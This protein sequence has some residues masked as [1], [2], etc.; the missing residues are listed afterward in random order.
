MELEITNED[1]LDKFNED[2]DEI[3]RIFSLDRSSNLGAGRTFEYWIAHRFLGF[4][5]ED[6][7]LVV[8]G[9]SGDKGIDIGSAGNI[10]DTI[11][12]VQCKFSNSIFEKQYPSYGDDVIEELIRGHKKLKNQNDSASASFNR[13]ITDFKFAENQN[14]TLRRI[15]C[16]TGKFNDEAIELARKNEIEI[17]DINPILRH[18]RNL[19]SFYTTPPTEINIPVEN[20]NFVLRKDSNSDTKAVILPIHAYTIYQ[21]VKENG[22]A[23]FAGNLRLR[24]P[25]TRQNSIGREIRDVALGLL[26]TENPYD[27]YNFEIL[28]NGLNIVCDSIQ[29]TG[30]FDPNSREEYINFHD[31]KILEAKL[32][33][34]QIVNGCQTS[35]AIHD[36]VDTRLRDKEIVNQNDLYLS[37]VYVWTKIIPTKKNADLIDKITTASNTQNPITK[38]DLKANHPIN[39][40][41][42]EILEN[43]DI[44]IFYENKRSL[45]ASF[46]KY[47][48]GKEELNKFKISGKSFRKISIEDFAQLS[49]AWQGNPRI[50]RSAKK[51]IFD[52]NDY[53]NEA[54]NLDSLDESQ[55]EGLSI[56][57]TIV[58]T[59]AIR[60]LSEALKSLYN[61][62]DTKIRNAIINNDQNNPYD[63]I[64]HY[65][66]KRGRFIIY[67]VSV[68]YWN[69]LI[70]SLVRQIIE[71]Y[72]VIYNNGA[73]KRELFKDLF[74]FTD[75][76]LINLSFKSNISKQLNFD[77]NLH[78]NQ[79]INCSDDQPNTKLNKIAMWLESFT[80]IFPDAIKYIQQIPGYK[81]PKDVRNFIEQKNDA[82]DKIFDYI[83]SNILSDSKKRDYYFPGLE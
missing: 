30:L 73:K 16:V 23:I 25:I 62:K 33:H 1:Y 35:W 7:K 70:V 44:P 71:H 45:F 79:L 50:A 6:T 3:A 37:N 76:D 43:A 5:E 10:S 39:D 8:I 72:I 49:M 77:E 83:K 14:K 63:S 57:E 46:S 29:F 28:N 56:Y 38:M 75:I 24:L 40:K 31:E 32:F 19:G 66:N 4:S 36:A 81:F 2:L 82:C 60:N 80:S 69:Y 18:V 34:P 27:D 68:R 53:F 17:Y 78:S 67:N 64:E 65:Q 13:L 11:I 42:K 61:L 22:D 55:T 9:E 54:F 74:D 20:L 21:I 51:S 59:N 41:I 12:L 26:R 48:S 47:F 52:N 15:V 58:F